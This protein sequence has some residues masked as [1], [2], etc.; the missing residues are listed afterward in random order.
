[1]KSTTSSNLEKSYDTKVVSNKKQHTEA[2]VNMPSVNYN[3]NHRQEVITAN[4]KDRLGVTALVAIMEPAT[5]SQSGKHTNN[6]CRVAPVTQSK[7]YWT[8][9]LMETLFSFQKE[10]TS[11]FPT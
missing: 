10:K 3:V 11:L 1:M 8:L 5:E 2:N 9:G 7:S 6:P 4:T